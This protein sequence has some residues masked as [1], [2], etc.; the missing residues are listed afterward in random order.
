[1]ITF[2]NALKVRTGTSY[3]RTQKA[4]DIN[5]HAEQLLDKMA[6]LECD[7]VVNYYLHCAYHHLA[8]NAVD[9]P[10]EIDDASGCAIE[11]AH[12]PIKSALL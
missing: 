9:C 7:E 4:E 5:F 11:H 2:F 10:I 1:M 8:D 12:Q 3:T 6:V